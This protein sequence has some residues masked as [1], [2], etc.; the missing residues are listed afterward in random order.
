MRI[1]GIMGAMRFI[2]KIGVIVTIVTIVNIVTIVPLRAQATLS[3]DTIVL[4][5]TTVL[6]VKGVAGD[7][8]RGVGGAFVEVLKE[9]WNEKDSVRTVYLTSFDPGVRYVR[10]SEKDSLRLMVLGVDIDPQ[11]DE[12]EDIADIDDIVDTEE[13][14]SLGDSE[15]KGTNW[16]L[17]SLILAGIAIAGLLFWWLRKKGKKQRE[18]GKVSAPRDDRNPLERAQE[19]LEELRKKQL[20]QSG[21]VKEYY[22][23]L[24]D[25]LRVF[26]EE[27][28]GIRATEMTS[29]ECVNALMCKC[30]SVDATTL[31]KNIFMTADLVKFA[32]GEPMPHEHQRAYEQSAAFVK[33][34]WESVNGNKGKDGNHA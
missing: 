12:I 6:T 32:K 9:E 25:T 11:S 10:W 19:R 14:E 16:W 1:M 34:M 7:Q 33:E 20:W 24:T 21:R 5:D 22:T 8:W 23:E 4:G 27:T 18:E 28:T 17:V 29:E 3:A 2:G 26:I 13:F 31:L 15:K 30:V